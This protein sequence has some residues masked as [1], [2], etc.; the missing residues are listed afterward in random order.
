MLD[1]EC[2]VPVADSRVVVNCGVQGSGV[3]PGRHNQ[4]VFGVVVAVG[5]GDVDVVDPPDAPATGATVQTTVTVR[6][7]VTAAAVTRR[8]SPSGR[9]KGP[10][11]S[12]VPWP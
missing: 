11:Q 10:G 9:A 5:A 12:R 1:G 2:V 6:V 4:T 8:G 7:T 3:C